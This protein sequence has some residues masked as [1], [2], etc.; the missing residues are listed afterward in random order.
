MQL[1]WRVTLF[2]P[3][4]PLCCRSS[5]GGIASLMVRGSQVRPRTQDLCI[6]GGHQPQA[7]PSRAPGQPHMVKIG[8]PWYWLIW[9]GFLPSTLL[10]NRSFHTESRN[11]AGLGGVLSSLNASLDFCV[12]CYSGLESFVAFMNFP[13]HPHKVDCGQLTW[14]TKLKPCE[15]MTRH[16]LRGQPMAIASAIWQNSVTRSLTGAHS[17]PCLRWA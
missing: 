15:Q 17:C 13:S 7:Q 14:A 6:Q 11:K 12:G 8:A 10:H 2:H 16:L 1:E 3:C 4:V 5:K 9:W